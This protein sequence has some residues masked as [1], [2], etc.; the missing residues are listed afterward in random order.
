MD[1]VSGWPGYHESAAIKWPIAYASGVDSNFTNPSTFPECSNISVDL[2]AC[3]H[4][5][6][7]YAKV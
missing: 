6:K 7:G 3:I 4:I 1:L 5:S 2:A